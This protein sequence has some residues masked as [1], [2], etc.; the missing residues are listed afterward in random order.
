MKLEDLYLINKEEWLD[1]I[2]DKCK[3]KAKTH[4]WV[5]LVS[6][7]LLLIMVT[8][9]IY[10]ELHPDIHYSAHDKRG[11]VLLLAMVLWALMSG[12]WILKSHSFLK[13]IDGLGNPEQLLDKFKKYIKDKSIIWTIGRLIFIGWWVYYTFTSDLGIIVKVITW[14]LF[15]AAAT[16]D[17]SRL[18]RGKYLKGSSDEDITHRLQELIGEE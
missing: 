17:I 5:G 15:L 9:A 10:V 12:W 14:I 4:F 1:V 6:L 11:F 7:I 16:V 3:K 2:K 13:T 8:I 18:I